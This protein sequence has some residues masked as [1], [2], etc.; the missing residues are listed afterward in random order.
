[1]LS[2]FIH[3]WIGSNK[4]FFFIFV[5]KVMQK[6]KLVPLK[7]DTVEE[8]VASFRQYSDEVTNSSVMYPV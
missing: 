5:F 1:M 4:R 2:F 6:L 8:R 3:Y 7:N